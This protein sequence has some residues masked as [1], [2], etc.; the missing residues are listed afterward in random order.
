M[1]YLPD[2]SREPIGR[3]L[4]ILDYIEKFPNSNHNS[5]MKQ[6]VIKDKLMAKKTFEKTI[7]SLISK[8]IVKSFKSKN[9]KIYVRIDDFQENYDGTLEKAT[10]TMF[11]FLEHEIK[12]I[13][14]SYKSMT[15]E[16]KVFNIAYHFRNVLQTDSGFTILDSM[17]NR[18]E[19]LYV[20]EHQKNQQFMARLLSIVKNDK[21]FL[22]VYPVVMNSLGIFP[23]ASYEELENQR[24]EMAKLQ[25]S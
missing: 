4:I 23:P 17:K 5:L 16:D 13:E 15:I 25:N 18:D 20:D 22:T 21:D 14:S 2:E 7:H 1:T 19:T 10:N 9:M 3:E 12:R 11:R 24:K 8:G 6:V